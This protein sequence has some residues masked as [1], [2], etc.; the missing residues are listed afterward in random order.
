MVPYFI[1]FDWRR[2]TQPEILI[3][4]NCTKQAN[5]FLG[6][7]LGRAFREDSLLPSTNNLVTILPSFSDTSDFIRHIIYF[8][9]IFGR[10]RYTIRLTGL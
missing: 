3:V 4:L 5:L 1:L 8:A 9:G 6:V 2:R 10:Q 7:F